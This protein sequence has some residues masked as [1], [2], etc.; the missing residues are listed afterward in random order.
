MLTTVQPMAEAELRARFKFSC[1]LYT[2]SFVL[3]IARSSMA[4]CC[5]KFII[6]H[7]RIPF[8]TAAKRLSSDVPIGL[9]FCF[10]IL[11]VTLSYSLNIN[12]NLNI[13]SSFPATSNQLAN[14][15]TRRDQKWT[16]SG[17][18]WTVK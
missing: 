13:A 2:F 15:W 6:L 9:K 16:R 8:P 10:S 18:K 7:K 5:D 3:L 4:S 14:S 12:L 17:P 11:V 1:F